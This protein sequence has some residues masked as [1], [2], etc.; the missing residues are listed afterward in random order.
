MFPGFMSKMVWAGVFFLAA[1]TLA[2]W[3]DEPGATVELFDTGTS[4]AAPLPGEVVAKGSGWSKL[5]EGEA[6]HRFK[7]DAVVSN[8]RVSVVLRRGAPGAE[9]YASSANGPILRAVLAPLTGAEKPRLWSVA[10]ASSSLSAAA[11]DV[12]FASADGK[13]AVVRFEL[14][15]GQVFVKTEPRREVKGLRVEAP[16]RFAILPDFFAADIAVD[17]TE[18][19]VSRAELPSENFLLHMVGQGEAIVLA[20]WNQREQDV[21]VSLGGEG[22]ARVIQ[23]SEIPYGNKGV[24][25]VAVLEGAG[26]WHW[27]DVAKADAN[28]A[29]GLGWKPPFAAQWRMDWRQDDGLT[30]SWEMLAQRPDGT[31]E[32]HDWFGQ[33]DAY[34]TPDWM[35]ADRKRW[36][37]VLG[38]F[39]YP[40]WID[41]DGQ[42]FIQPLKGPGKFQGPAIVYP[43]S[44]T[45][46]T[47]LTAVTF[48]DIVRDTLGVGPCEYILDIEGQ[49]KKS[50]GIPTCAT[51]TRLNGIYADKQQ[52]QKKAEVEKALADVL[53][54]I[55]HIRNRIESYVGFGHQMLAYLEEQKKAQPHLAKVI[56]EL[57]TLTR[58]IDAAVAARQKGIHTPEHAT[59]LVEE[60]R[61][62]L[63]DYEGE[64]ALEKCKKITAGFV[65]IGGNQDELVGE[66]RLAVK[67]LRQKAGLAVAA[68]PRAAGIAREIRQRT[69][70]MLRNPASYEA[71][72]H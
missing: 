42:G 44:R 28:K 57:E 20:V 32:R 46:A 49:K 10:I 12:H 6:S 68:D 58:R 9:L 17:A 50:E 21:Q 37:T 39:Q 26:M 27:R 56:A 13:D 23:A 63:V 60:F 53:A 4:S 34:G 25:S 33:S 43:I 65:E 7:G 24:I 19:P 66:C 30:D 1:Q 62:S 16:C 52:K 69:H 2:A 15:V 35:Q 59:G 8:G 14:Q 41:K 38:S 36:T 48:I 45:S 29:I 3:A 71:P 64:D 61:T 55:R 54:F 51:R 11:L 22:H 67:M 47:P 70:E 31:Y 40:C 18:L 72:R 5:P